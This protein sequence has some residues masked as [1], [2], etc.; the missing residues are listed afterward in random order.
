MRTTMFDL[1]RSILWTWKVSPTGSSLHLA[2][3]QLSLHS[4]VVVLTEQDLRMGLSCARAY[5]GGNKGRSRR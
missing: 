3:V 5:R 4:H 1:E 2:Q